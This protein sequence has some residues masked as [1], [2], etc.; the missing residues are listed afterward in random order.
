VA[1]FGDPAEAARLLRNDARLS[2]LLGGARQPADG[3]RGMRARLAEYLY[4]EAS[5]TARE[6]GEEYLN[7]L[8]PDGR[9]AVR[10]AKTRNILQK[11]AKESLLAVCGQARATVCFLGT[12]DPDCMEAFHRDLRRRK[13]ATGDF[14]KESRGFILGELGLGD[15][16]KAVDGFL[17][18]FQ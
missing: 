10:V 12:E 15:V 13:N 11:Y 17:A 14:Q 6:R 16:N 7:S 3:L 18:V 8:G 5:A 1:S 2:E 4:G 9:A